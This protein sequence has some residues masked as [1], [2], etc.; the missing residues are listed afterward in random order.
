MRW[1]TLLVLVLA[2][3]LARAQ[4]GEAEK[5]FRA[6]EKKLLAAKSLTLEY[7]TK[8]DADGKTATVKGTIYI[9]ADNKLRFE[10]TGKGVGVPNAK[11]L[12]L[13]N[14]DK[15]FEKTGDMIAAKPGSPRKSKTVLG[16]LA[17]ANAT[18]AL[19]EKKK[20]QAGPLDIDEDFPVKN[21]KLGAK[22]KADKR[23]AQVVHYEYLRSKLLYTHAVWIDTKT[24]LPLKRTFSFTTAKGNTLR[25][26]D[27]Y[28]KFTVDSKLDGKLFEIPP[29]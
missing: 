13:T 2:P 15:V 14:G 29:K 24:Q 7:A 16:I 17:R 28:S 1:L 8:F 10:A 19:F 6:M 25:T 4:E 11:I 23:E 3:A 26:T 12:E 5:L 9:D 18:T 21:F 27:I 22:E 20:Y